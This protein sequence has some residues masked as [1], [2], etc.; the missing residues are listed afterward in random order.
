MESTRQVTHNEAE[1][2]APVADKRARILIAAQSVFG[3]L[4]FSRA[5]IKHIASEAGVGFGLVAHYFGSKEALFLESGLAMAQSLLETLAAASATQEKGLDSLE[6]VIAAYFD[7]TREKAESFPVVFRCSPFS[8]VERKLDRDR[9]A[10]KFLEIIDVMRECVERGV[11]DGSIRNVPVE[12]MGFIVYGTLVGALRTEFL[13]PF[14]VQ[15]MFQ[16]TIAFVRQALAA[17]PVLNT[18]PR[19]TDAS[20]A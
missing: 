15:G 4:G 16:E 20:H 6:A 18:P 5:T 19:M 10:S 2:Q 17:E 14:K 13:S 12:P 11:R 1:A 8:D 7:F 9:I 3:R